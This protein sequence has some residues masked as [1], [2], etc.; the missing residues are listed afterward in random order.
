MPAPPTKEQ[1]TVFNGIKSIY[2]ENYITEFT[3]AGVT[4]NCV[5]QFRQHRKAQLFDDDVRAAK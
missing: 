2:H 3:V 4:Y 5:K 1:F